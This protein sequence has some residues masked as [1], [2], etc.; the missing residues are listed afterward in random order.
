MYCGFGWSVE[1]MTQETTAESLAKA[2]SER[3][4]WAT[5]E[6]ELHGN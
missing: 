2:G 1:W 5:E 6:P 4:L 3:A